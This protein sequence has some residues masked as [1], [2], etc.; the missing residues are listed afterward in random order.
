M[1]GLLRMLTNPVAGENYLEPRADAVSG[2]S[3]I[4]R[5]AASRVACILH[6][7]MSWP[8]AFRFRMRVAFRA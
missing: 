5:G 7:R 6:V 4:E 8:N 2:N 3:I 1:E